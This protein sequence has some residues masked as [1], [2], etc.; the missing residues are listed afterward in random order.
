[1]AGKKER[2]LLHGSKETRRSPREMKA[3]RQRYK[4]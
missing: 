1:M 3:I 2:E 4:K